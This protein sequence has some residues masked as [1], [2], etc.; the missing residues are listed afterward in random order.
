MIKL[1]SVDVD[2]TL[3]DSEG[4]LPKPNRDAI[5]RLLQQGVHVV[6]NTGKPLSCVNALVTAL[7]LKDAVVT[8]SGSLILYCDSDHVWKC[9]RSCPI[10]TRSIGLLTE[11]LSGLPISILV[12]T[13]EYFYIYHSRTDPAYL[14]YFEQMLTRNQVSEYTLLTQSPFQDSHILNTEPWLKIQTHT[15]D[16]SINRALYQK[17]QAANLSGH[18][19]RFS[20]PGS[21]DIYARHSGKKEAI[22][23][24]CRTMGIERGEVLAIGDHE[25]D[26]PL[27]QWAGKG[28]IMA[29]A[30]DH[31]RQAAPNIAPCN[32]E[33][34]LAVVLQTQCLDASR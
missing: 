24:L 3:L 14:V 22:Q 9:L 33:S 13:Q 6:L 18:T 5:K 27:T 32:D 10:D 21:L 23:Y 2:G 17:L 12:Y 15:N 30:P 34:G 26:L 31:V 1:V 29:N 11:L 8:L 7:G 20:S 19:F 28:Y 16:E 4:N 25:T